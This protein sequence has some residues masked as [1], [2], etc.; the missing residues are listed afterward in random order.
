MTALQY[1]EAAAALQHGE[2][3]AALQNGEA[4]AALQHGEATAA[5]QHGEAPAAL[6]H[7]KRWLL[8]RFR[9]WS[10]LGMDTSC[11]KDQAHHPSTRFAL[12]AYH[13][14]IS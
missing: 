3:A 5:L 13:K 12:L 2:A 1:G 4:A 14:D 9:A 7:V 10:R 8:R 6:Q 11:V